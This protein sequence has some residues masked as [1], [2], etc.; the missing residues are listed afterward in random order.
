M[1]EWVALQEPTGS[2]STLFLFASVADVVAAPSEKER[3][4]NIGQT[5]HNPVKYISICKKRFWKS[6]DWSPIQREPQFKKKYIEWV[7]G[8]T[9]GGGA[10]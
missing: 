5:V 1:L 6:Y 2:N 8:E 3:Q 10:M 7:G 4:F 9:R